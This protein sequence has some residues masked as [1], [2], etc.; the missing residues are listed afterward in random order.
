[1][2]CVFGRACVASSRTFLAP[3]EPPL[4]PSSARPPESDGLQRCASLLGVVCHER[5][6]A[7]HAQPVRGAP[8]RRGG[9]RGSSLSPCLAQYLMSSPQS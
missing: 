3:R 8:S 9:Q 4:F 6:A 7:A 2:V 1:M 5:S